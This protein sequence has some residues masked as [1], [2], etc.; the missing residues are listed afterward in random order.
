VSFAP[1]TTKGQVS[2]P[3]VNGKKIGQGSSGHLGV[4]A[5][6]VIS[7]MSAL[8]LILGAG[9]AFHYAKRPTQN[10]SVSQATGEEGV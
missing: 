6:A 8:V 3:G 9:L 5:T 4:S 7:G 10:T 2:D 1:S